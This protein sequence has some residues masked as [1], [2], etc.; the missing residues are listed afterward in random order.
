MC[1]GQGVVHDHLTLW[2]TAVNWHVQIN[3]KWPVCCN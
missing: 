3:V 2:K 1:N